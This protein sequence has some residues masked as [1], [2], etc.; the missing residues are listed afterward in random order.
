MLNV[1]NGNQGNLGIG[2]ALIL[3]V[4]TTYALA[5]FESHFK[6]AQ[7]AS[8]QNKKVVLSNALHDFALSLSQPEECLKL[9]D[10]IDTAVPLGDPQTIATKSKKSMSG[11]SLD[12]LSLTFFQLSQLK[13]ESPYDI[14]TAQ[15]EV[16]LSVPGK[17]ELRIVDS[18]SLSV[19]LSKEDR[20]LL[21]CTSLAD[22]RHFEQSCPKGFVPVGVHTDLTPMCKQLTIESTLPSAIECPE[23]SVAQAIKDGQISCAT[24]TDPEQKPA[25]TP[26]PK[27]KTV[28]SR[29]YA[30]FEHADSDTSPE[31]NPNKQLN[32][33]EVPASA[34]TQNGVFL[35][36]LLSIELPDIGTRCFMLTTPWAKCQAPAGSGF[37]NIDCSDIVQ[38]RL[39][40]R[41]SQKSPWQRGSI[42]NPKLEADIENEI[43]VSIT[44]NALTLFWI[45]HEV[46]V[47]E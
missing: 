2:A 23:G 18:I 31:Y 25:E 47:C 43:G 13:L 38:E 28:Q 32:L 26:T 5:S 11:M 24:V 35:G 6:F 27:C 37:G 14:R 46:S 45:E 19:S 8:Q 42:L 12:A 4:S 41:S 29:Y 21:S 1:G 15:L 30:L 17:P 40:L 20:T 36:R 33:F 34:C 9:L 39:H 10:G 44:G 22:A 3:A 16:V 7:R